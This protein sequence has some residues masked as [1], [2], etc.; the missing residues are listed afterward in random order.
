MAKSVDDRG[1]GARLA[2]RDEGAYCWY[3][4]EEQRRQPGCIGC[5]DD[6]L[7]HSRALSGRGERSASRSPMSAGAHFAQGTSGEY[8]VV[9]AAIECQLRME[10]RCGDVALPHQHGLAAVPQ[11]NFHA[12]A[13]ALDAWCANE[14]QAQRLARCV[15]RTRQGLVRVRLEAV[16]L[17]TVR[18]AGH[19]Y[20]QNVEATLRRLR[21]RVCQQ[22]QAS[23]GREHGAPRSYQIEERRRKAVAPDQIE[24]HRALAAGQ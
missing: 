22:D 8:Q 5:E 7:S 9:Y 11:Q 16:E 21:Y 15:A 17:A 13:H 24:L 18:V 3:V 14:H 23:A 4:T 12:G 1:R 6:R 19:V 10:S 2:R 20:V